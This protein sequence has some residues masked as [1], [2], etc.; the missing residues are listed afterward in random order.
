MTVGTK[1][2]HDDYYEFQLG[3]T[4]GGFTK[5]STSNLSEFV[6]TRPFPEG[7][8]LLPETGFNQLEH[9]RGDS[10]TMVCITLKPEHYYLLEEPSTSSNTTSL[11][12]IVTKLME[13]TQYTVAI[14][15][16]MTPTQQE[17]KITATTITTRRTNKNGGKQ[18][19]SSSY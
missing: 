13:A 1:S 3:K 2:K 11:L 19:T 17:T 7:T 5:E 4:N 18:T 14:S 15:S 8:R 6:I 10:G 9:I 16:A 12:S